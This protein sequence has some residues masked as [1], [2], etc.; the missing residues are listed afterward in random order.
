[1]KTLETIVFDPIQCRVEIAALSKLLRSSKNL[2]ER[3]DIQRF[4][5]KRKQLS[6]FIGTFAPNIGLA[7]RLAY[8]FPIRGDFA[9]DPTVVDR[10]AA[11]RRRSLFQDPNRLQ[12]HRPRRRRRRRQ[13][14]HVLQC[15]RVNGD[16][17][18]LVRVEPCAR[19]DQV[20]QYHV[21]LQTHQV[22]HLA[23]QRGFRSRCRTS[24]ALSCRLAERPHCPDTAL[25]G[26]GF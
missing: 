3:E 24:A 19:R 15:L 14:R 11:H 7:N 4:F 2:A 16:L 1:M 20:A 9:A 21:F 6:A 26:E 18:L 10:Q 17:R 23:G 12:L 8:E 22:I 5:R 13:L 25:R